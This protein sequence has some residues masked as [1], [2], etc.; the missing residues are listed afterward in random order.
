MSRLWFIY[1]DNVQKGPFTDDEMIHYIQSSGIKAK[2]LAWTEGMTEWAR[3]NHISEFY[4]VLNDPPGQDDYYEEQTF[5][6]SEPP[7]APAVKEPAAKQEP[8]DKAELTPEPMP[9]SKKE[10][11]TSSQSTADKTPAVH[12]LPI[13][14]PAKEH[15]KAGEPV[16]ASVKKSSKTK[17]PIIAAA[18]AVVLIGGGLL[19][20]NLISDRPEITAGEIVE[21]VEEAPGEEGETAAEQPQVPRGNTPGN[22][23]QG[24]FV[25]AS[26]GWVYFSI[27]E[28]ERLIKM[29][30]DGTEKQVLVEEDA[31]SIT[32]IQYIN[33]IGDWLYYNSG[34]DIVKVQTDGSE[35][36]VVEPLAGAMSLNV[37]G[38]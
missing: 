11:T 16:A 20:Y 18:L 28:G 22:I 32:G 13:S 2:D 9:I 5:A 4:S 33:L 35:R 12:S 36:T 14:T 3:I 17:L 38:D 23:S 15:S 34:S 30:S 37:V 26:D 21:I 24:G 8:Q 6:E 1:Q 10:Y 25:A 27:P 29:R 31:S 19:V 7:S